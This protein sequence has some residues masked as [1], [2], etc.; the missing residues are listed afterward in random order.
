MDGNV[1]PAIPTIII[2][3]HEDKEKEKPTVIAKDTPQVAEQVQQEEAIPGAMPS[4]PANAIPDWYKVGW[5]QMTGIDEPH[6]LEG[7]EADK[8][9][10]DMFLSEQFYGAW[11]HNAA[12]IVVVRLS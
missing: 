3:N 1:P 5:R 11:Y 8:R 7:E 6:L 10:L 2:E 4:K 9:V 12:I